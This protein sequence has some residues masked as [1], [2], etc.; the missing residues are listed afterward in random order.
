MQETYLVV[1]WLRLHASTAGDKV[2][3]PDQGTKAPH[4]MLQAVHEEDRV[5]L[6]GS[7]EPGLGQIKCLNI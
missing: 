3:I 7:G 2:L 1:H 4:A 6:G 5:F